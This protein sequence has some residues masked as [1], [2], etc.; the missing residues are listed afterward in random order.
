M[1]F[2][3]TKQMLLFFC[4]IYSALAFKTIIVFVPTVVMID[5]V[6]KRPYFCRANNR[7]LVLRGT[8]AVDLAQTFCGKVKLPAS[9]LI[10]GPTLIIFGFTRRI[11]IYGIEIKQTT[12]YLNIKCSKYI[13]I[14]LF[15]SFDYYF[16]RIVIIYIF[17]IYLAVNQSLHYAQYEA[18][19]PHDKSQNMS[20]FCD[21][22]I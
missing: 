8:A 5:E 14:F 16:T 7:N 1:G 3:F 12:F 6:V 21:L 17:S 2:Y 15:T 4:I 11:Q 20:C 18:S 13:L 19:T 22:K 10:I 9:L